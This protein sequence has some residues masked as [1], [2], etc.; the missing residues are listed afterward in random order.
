MCDVVTN[1]EEKSKLEGWFKSRNCSAFPTNHF[2]VDTKNTVSFCPI[3]IT[4][5]TLLMS[6]SRCFCNV[7]NPP[8]TPPNNPTPTNADV[9]TIH[10][11]TQVRFLSLKARAGNTVLVMKDTWFN[12]APN[13]ARRKE[14]N[15]CE[16]F[17]SG[18]EWL[19]FANLEGWY[20]WWSEQQ[21]LNRHSTQRSRVAIVSSLPVP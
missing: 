7:Q 4:P 13:D 11:R 5:T 20:R 9:S 10:Q 18:I 15:R 21:S 6:R 14:N 16:I 1:S 17:L 2:H 19:S 12:L 3:P 8:A